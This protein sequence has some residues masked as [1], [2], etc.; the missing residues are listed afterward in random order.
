MAAFQD[1]QSAEQLIDR[2]FDKW[3]V[4]AT[5]DEDKWDGAGQSEIYSALHPGLGRHELLIGLCALLRQHVHLCKRGDEE[6]AE[7]IEHCS[8]R[9]VPAD[10]GAGSE[11]SDDAS[12]SDGTI[13]KGNAGG[14]YMTWQQSSIIDAF[15][16]IDEEILAYTEREHMMILPGAGSTHVMAGRY[17]LAGVL[18]ILLER[19]V[20]PR[21]EG[22]ARLDDELLQAAKLIDN[23]M[24]FK[25]KEARVKTNILYRQQKFNLLREENEGFS[26]ALEVILG[27]M[28]P[29]VTASIEQSSGKVLVHE[30]EREPIRKKRAAKIWRNLLALIG[31]FDLEPNRVLDLIL[32]LFITNVNRHY[33]FFLS[34]IAASQWGSA[35]GKERASSDECMNDSADDLGQVKWLEEEKGNYVCA[36][37]M[38]FKLKYYMKEDVREDA[39]LE[40][41]VTMALLIRHGF[42]KTTAILN[43]ILNKDAMCVAHDAYKKS[44]SEMASAASANAL[45]MS[46]PLVDDDAGNRVTAKNEEEKKG[47]LKTLQIVGAIRAFL[48]L[49]MLQHATLLLAKWPWILTAHEDV[50]IL[51]C[52]LLRPVV[53]RVYN[54]MAV[55]AASEEQP[56]SAE[57]NYALVAPRKWDTKKGALLPPPPPTAEI[58]F[59]AP[60]PPDTVAKRFSFFYSDW[61]TQ[62]PTPSTA[63]QF[64]QTVYPLLKMLGYNLYV[65]PLLFSQICRITGAGFT[66]CPGFDEHGRNQWLDIVRGNLLGACSLSDPNTAILSELWTVFKTLNYE[67]RFKLYG[68]WKSLYMKPELKHCKT[69]TEKEAKGVLKRVSS[70]PKAQRLIGRKLAKAAH[71]NPIIF[72]AVALNQVQSYENMIGPIVEAARSLTAL[73][74]DIFTWSLLDSLSAEKQRMKNDGTNLAGWLKSL[75]AFAGALYKRYSLMDCG[76]VLQYIVNQLHENNAN[77]LIVMRE[78]ILKLSGIEPL[79]NPSDRQVEASAG[80]DALKREA[81][82]ANDGGHG[83]QARA[84]Y[85]KNG[86]R[87]LGMVRASGMMLPLLILI[88]QQQDACIHLVADEEAH[89]KFLGQLFDTC[90]EVLFQYVEFLNSFLDAPTYASTIPGLQALVERFKIR[91]AIAFHIARPELTRLMSKAE[92]KARSERLRKLAADTKAKV[93]AAAAAAECAKGQEAN[94]AS[95]PDAA[96]GVDGTEGKEDAETKVAEISNTVDGAQETQQNGDASMQDAVSN[97]TAVERA[98]AISESTTIP[99]KCEEAE[100]VE[101]WWQD[102]LSSVEAAALSFLPEDF[103]SV[104]S[105]GFYAT[106]WQLSLSDIEVPVQRYKQEK[107]AILAVYANA[108]SDRQGEQTKR[109]LAEASNTL[110]AEQKAQEERAKGTKLRLEAERKTWFVQGSLQDDLAWA[111]LQHCILPRSLLSPA[112]AIFSAKFI[113]L[114][115]LYGADNLS[116]ITLYNKLFEYVRPTLFMT[117]ENEAR[118]YS[119]FLQIILADLERW[120]KDATAY[121]NEAVPSHLHGFDTV[122]ED[123]TSTKLEHVDFL[124]VYAEWHQSLFD[125]FSFCI[126]SREYM[127]FRNT[128]VVMTRVAELFPIL[129]DHGSKLV[130]KVEGAAMEEAREDLKILLQGLLAVLKKH[131]KRWLANIKGGHWEPKQKL[132]PKLPATKNSSAATKSLR[133][134]NEPAPSANAQ[135]ESSIAA[136]VD[137]NGNVSADATP[138]SEPMRSTSIRGVAA[139]RRDQEERTAAE[140]KAVSQAPAPGESSADAATARDAALASM[141]NGRAASSASGRP[142]TPG[143]TNPAETPRNL[144]STEIPIR[145]ETSEEPPAGPSAATLATPHQPAAEEA[146]NWKPSRE[147]RAASPATVPVRLTRDRRGADALSIRARD[148]DRRDEERDQNRRSDMEKTRDREADEPS[149]DMKK[150][151][152]PASDT[153]RRWGR[154]DSTLSRGPRHSAGSNAVEPPRI[155]R[156]R[157]HD[158]QGPSSRDGRRGSRQASPGDTA[159]DNVSIPTGP[160]A[161]RRP[162]GR[163]AQ[164]GVADP[165]ANSPSGRKRGRVEEPSALAVRLGSQ[166]TGTPSNDPSDPK[167]PR[168]GDSPREAKGRNGTRADADTDSGKRPSSSARDSRDGQGGTHKGRGA[169]L[170]DPVGSTQDSGWEGRR[171]KK[172][173]DGT[174]E[175]RAAWEGVRAKRESARERERAAELEADHSRDRHRGDDRRRGDRDQRDSA[176]EDRDLF[177]EPSRPIDRDRAQREADRSGRERE[178]DRDYPRGGGHASTTRGGDR[179]RM[180]DAERDAGRPSHTD[181]LIDLQLESTSASLSE[182]SRGESGRSS[183]RR[184][185]REGR[186]GGR[187]D[188]SD[189]RSGAVE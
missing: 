125:A 134:G 183:G 88:A 59:V 184:R 36:Q 177:T 20:V 159:R 130:V 171:I 42:I 152:E 98:G 153:I 77:D 3:E 92:H 5:D 93:A 181:R 103:T 148:R 144:L 72:F 14:R 162:S 54:T 114:L 80:G 2:C 127:R 75:A 102:V 170:A 43:H 124:K 110:E 18:Q 6:I 182:D 151:A 83:T 8:A 74:F 25:R 100:P 157:G 86:E 82:M 56:I 30:Q 120:R 186:E 16:L 115:H 62:L 112:D 146:R 7:L 126:E 73:E 104:A 58:V 101:P 160:A 178:R 94:I 49:G 79:A 164:P 45:T 23:A 17:K 121:S 165:S 189:R 12:E 154:N 155:E 117:T 41:H 78:L 174:R 131:E 60:P 108:P 167:R 24:D 51:F 147:S 106:F 163:A 9:A 21:I 161:D 55:S 81:T 65:D 67:A 27:G 90:S 99:E 71:S 158:T 139:A 188:R 66:A 172:E 109:R 175:Q 156:S 123:G 111:V 84:L 91:P 142:G 50:A 168:L 28:G 107:N 176:R 95:Q 187:R 136:N 19:E 70:D 47:P 34:L 4:G 63:E 179:A 128:I 137:V 143:R 149:R 97:G 46:A 35:K 38:G 10:P 68:E 33:P 150:E 52:R 113:R 145:R 96:E 180:S 57:G 11:R 26:K 132:P 166:P 31:Y 61:H 122:S 140:Q 44:L 40:V 169:N 129:G 89:L 133:P 119:R 1:E 185:K 53:R 173:E 76:P 141:R 15:W 105:A 22:A 135:R 64:L 37:I 138:P 85:Q 118:N 32:D 29:P 87:L 69:R 13:S 48:S 39:P 116:T